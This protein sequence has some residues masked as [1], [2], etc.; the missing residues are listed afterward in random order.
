MSLENEI[1]ELTLA[2]KALTAVLDTKTAGPLVFGTPTP[3][4]VNEIVSEIARQ[5]VAEEQAAAVKS[6]AKKSKA[7]TS[8][9]TAKSADT[10]GETS[11]TTTSAPSQ[12]PPGVPTGKTPSVE[13]LRAA[14]MALAKKD[15][16]L[17]KA[18]VNKYAGSISAV[19]EEDRADLIKEV[20]KLCKEI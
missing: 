3:V 2:V 13:E 16:D 10:A 14:V 18:T 8:E 11:Q 1:K 9:A 6:S 5:Q 19:A 12:E 20:N 15:N 17:A 4:P 7:E